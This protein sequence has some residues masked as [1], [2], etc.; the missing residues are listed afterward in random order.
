MFAESAYREG[1]KEKRVRKK[2]TD[3]TS[4]LLRVTHLIRVEYVPCEMSRKLKLQLEFSGN[5]TG[6][7]AKQLPRN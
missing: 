2:G 4:F 6:K 1:E 7:R 5:V 3:S